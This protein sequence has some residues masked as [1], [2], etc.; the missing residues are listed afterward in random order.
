[1]ETPAKGVSFDMSQSRLKLVWVN[2]TWLS[3]RNR[4]KRNVIAKTG[5]RANPLM[6]WWAWL[7]VNGSAISALVLLLGAP[8]YIGRFYVQLQNADQALYGDVG[9]IKRV[10][11]LHNDVVWMKGFVTGEYT[12]KV[13]NL[14]YK[15]DEVKI[16]PVRS[17]ESKPTAAPLFRTTQTAS[18]GA[19]YN[20][21]IA[22]MSAT[23]EQ[24]VLSVNREFGRDDF[25][26]NTLK[27]PLTVG[28]ALDLTEGVY[29]QG[30]PRIFLTVLAIP[31][32]ETAIIAIGPKQYM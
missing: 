14:G 2:G 4:I 28:T 15:K 31:T 21:E 27:V 12:E 3:S 24:A 18:G 8:W 30:M 17:S 9:L 5:K 7:R 19:Q 23:G 1:M 32:E 10:N 16:L 13:A 25:K 20:L 29:I 22:L 6:R 11:D 26:N